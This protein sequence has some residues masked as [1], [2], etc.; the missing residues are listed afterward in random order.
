LKPQR[1]AI[2]GVTSQS[3]YQWL[4]NHAR[5]LSG[6][7]EFGTNMTNSEQGVNIKCSKATGTTPGAANTDFTVKHILGRIPITL[8][9]W[10]TNN[11]GVIYRS[12]ATP[13]TKATATFRCT[14][15]SASY[16]IILV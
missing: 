7:I 14:T 6:N 1:L 10:D 3:L 8:A 4:T 9:G 16:N 11:G 12:P 5:V 2:G 15:A 13:W